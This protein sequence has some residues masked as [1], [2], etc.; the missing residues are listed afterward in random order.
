MILNYC[1]SM[2]EGRSC[3]AAAWSLY[4]PSHPLQLPPS[5]LLLV[6]LP[7]FLPPHPPPPRL[8]LEAVGGHPSDQG[9]SS[10]APHSLSL[11]LLLSSDDGLWLAGPGPRLHQSWWRCLKSSPRPSPCLGHEPRSPGHQFLRHGPTSRKET[12][13]VGGGCVEAEAASCKMR[14]RGHTASEGSS[15]SCQL[16][17][18]EQRAVF[19]CG[20]FRVGNV[21]MM[22]GICMS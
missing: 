8:L 10:S 6:F 14:E 11:S 22:W 3:V 17:V 18:S 19:L 2:C 5:C 15:A 13:V 16:H 9:S 1:L 7:P 4:V 12:A 21:C 20:G